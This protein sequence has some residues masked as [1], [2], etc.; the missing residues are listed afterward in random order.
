MKID[1]EKPIP[2]INQLLALN[3]FAPQNEK[4]AKKYGNKY[5]TNAE[6]AVYN[7]PFKVDEW[8]PEDKIRLTKI[9]S[10]G[11]KRMLN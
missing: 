2:Y 5:G 3:T 1:L 10:I 7:G 11:I 6:K 4:V 9:Q 8:K